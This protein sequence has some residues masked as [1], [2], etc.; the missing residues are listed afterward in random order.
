M[1]DFGEPV[2]C[3][4]PKMA[5]LLAIG[6]AFA[7]SS[8]A[9]AQ[10]ASDD[11]NARAH[12][13]SGRAYFDQARYEDAAREF[14]EAYRLSHRAEL[15]EN[16]SRSFERA[17]MFNEAIDALQRLLRDHPGQ[18]DEQTYRERITNLERLR[19]RLGNGGGG[20]AV[21]GGGGGGISIP[22]LVTL[23]GGGVL[24]L[25]A[26]ILAIA[27]QVMYDSVSAT[28]PNGVCPESRRGDVGAGAAVA[29]TSTI[30]T[31]AAPIAIGVGILLMVLDSGGGS[32]STQSRL[33][34]TPG[35]GDVG[36]GLTVNL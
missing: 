14:E 26:I 7:L 21:S 17:L 15:L 28:C 27:S 13:V 33:R 8:L 34:L 32:S 23:I 19:D 24:G 6:L 18:P 16:E 36:L 10:N 1:R 2:Y 30:L 20:A 29:W 31:F 5:R 35:P 12:F 9:H 4:R 11:E 25:T 3:C 22:S